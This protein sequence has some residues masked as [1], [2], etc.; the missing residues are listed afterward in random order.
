VVSEAV[1]TT[2][3]VI[4]LLVRVLVLEIEGIAT[5]PIVG[6]VNEGLTKS[7]LVVSKSVKLSLMT[8]LDADGWSVPNIVVIDIALLL[9]C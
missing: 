7:A 2:L 6:V 1:V 8:V 9:N 4:R 3:G 5:P